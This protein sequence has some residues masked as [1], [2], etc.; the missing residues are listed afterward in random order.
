MAPKL[1]LH[2][3]PG[4][5]R[6]GHVCRIVE[7]LYRQRRRVVIWM[8]DPEHLQALDDYLWSFAQLAF[9]PHASWTASLGE[10][11]EP[12][13][14]VS[15]P[16]NPNRA[17]V[18]VVGDELPPGDWAAGFDEVHDLV[19]AGEEGAERQAFWDRWRAEHGV[20]GGSG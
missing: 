10:L 12:V 3:Q 11:D 8:A 15:E 13:V 1:E 19:P 4:S 20:E 2:E 17:Q 6:A 18:L 16:A 5:K 7:E 14:L 9:V